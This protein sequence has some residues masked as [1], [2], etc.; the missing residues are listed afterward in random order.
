MTMRIAGLLVLCVFCSAALAQDRSWPRRTSGP[1]L[2]A[3]AGISHLE[4]DQSGIDIDDEDYGSQFFG[5]YLWRQDWLPVLTGVAVQAGYTDLGE[6]EGSSFELEADGYE[7]L[8]LGFA[9]VTPLLDIFAGAGVIAWDAKLSNTTGTIDSDNDTD[10]AFAGGVELRTS[11][12]ISGRAAVHS[13]DFVD[14]AW[15]LSL[16]AI[17]QFK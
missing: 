13:Y 10:L 6:A 7:F 8:V 2:G 11:S 15:L 14:G 4:F 17:Y 1:Y 3:G 9:Q 5:G 16:S 12:P